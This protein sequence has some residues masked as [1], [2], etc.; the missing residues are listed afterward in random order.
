MDSTERATMNGTASSLIF[1]Y[2]RRTVVHWLS[3]AL[4]LEVRGRVERVPAVH[5]EDDVV[6][7]AQGV[8]DRAQAGAQPGDRGVVG[9]V[10]KASAGDV[11]IMKKK[12][13]GFVGNTLEHIFGLQTL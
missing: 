13:L 6:V 9:H 4:Y 2:I 8:G 7:A 10:Q 11:L 5:V 1:L 12:N 3:R